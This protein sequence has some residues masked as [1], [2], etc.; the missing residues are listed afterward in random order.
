MDPAKDYRP[1]GFNLPA[2]GK[3]FT[4]ESGS[5]STDWPESVPA[6]GFRILQNI[7]CRTGQ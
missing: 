1:E 3:A 5:R 6:P 7:F 4:D 2:C